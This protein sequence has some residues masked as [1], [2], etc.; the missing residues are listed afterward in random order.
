MTWG[1]YEAYDAVG[2]AGLVAAGATTPAELL[3]AALA[4][5]EALNPRAQRGGPCCRRRG[6]AA[7]RG[8]ACRPGRSAACRSCSRISAPRRWTFR[9]TTARGCCAGTT[10]PGGLRASIA[11]LKRAGLVTFGRTTAPEGGIGAGDR[12]RGLRRAD[13]QSRGISPARPAA[14]RAAPAAAVAAGIVPAA[15]GSD[16]GGSVRIPA[17]SC[18]LFGFKPT[19]AP[20]ARRPLCRRGLG[21]HGDRRLPDPLGA[22]HGGAAGRHRGAPTSA[23]PIGRRRSPGSLPRRSPAA[24]APADRVRHHRA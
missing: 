3:D 10:L 4:R 7:D 24:A 23:R 11:R 13:A 21:R 16:G 12:G 8:R 9:R 6:A 1:D 5:V 22:R 17:S 2:L 18:G 15:H 14:R 20:P 19:R